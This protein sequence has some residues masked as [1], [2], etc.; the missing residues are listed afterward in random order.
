M[1]KKKTT[2]CFHYRPLKKRIAN[3]DKNIRKLFVRKIELKTK[4]IHQSIY[5]I[6]KV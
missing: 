5:N 3:D 4:I 6:R 1:R 2:L